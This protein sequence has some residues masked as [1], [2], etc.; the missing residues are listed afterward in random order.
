MNTRSSP[1]YSVVFVV[2]LVLAACSQSEKPDD[3]GSAKK[4]VPAEVFVQLFEW[5]W[6]DVARECE[7]VLGPHGYKGVQTSPAHEH[8]QGPQWWTRYQ[9]V[10]YKIESRGGT[11]EEFAAMVSRCKNAGVDIYADALTNHMSYV[12]SGVGV[13]GS[14]YSEY[15][16]PV[17]Y[18]FDDFHHCDRNGDGNIANYQDKWEVQ[19]CMLGSLA[20][21]DTGQPEVRAKIA[22]YLNDLLQLG[23]A[24][25]RLDAVKHI[26]NDEL[27]EILRLVDGNPVI[28]QEVPDRGGEPIKAQDYLGN[29]SV[30]EVKYPAA[31]TAA[32][33]NGDLE[34]LQ[35][36]ATRDGFLPADQSVVFV[37]NHDLQ[38]GH[39][40]SERILSYKDGS[41][42]ALATTFMLAYPYGYPMVMSSYYFDNSDQGPNEFASL[43]ANGACNEAWVCEHRRH[44]VTQMVKF[45]R[46]TAGADVTH[47]QVG[48]A[49]VLSFGRGDKGHV[50]F[51]VSDAAVDTVVASAMPTGSYCDAISG[52]VS[53]DGCSGKYVRVDDDGYIAVSLEPLSAVAIHIGGSVAPQADA[54]H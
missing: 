32:F 25:F 42:Y 52:M 54:R 41:R 21:L 7:T 9:P 45:R 2:L 15:S 26:A 1:G 28:L 20:D 35:Q 11:R 4:T 13:A 44:A 27:V 19:N 38:R 50:V 49:G 48:G 8:V 31:M 6:N 36:I 17:P 10:S 39:G 43:D 16:Y 23:V 46:V 12:G 34:S 51:N 30:I 47:W 37:D 22:A 18:E 53:A 14:A 5:R 40:G 33:L 3:A 24:G 29:G